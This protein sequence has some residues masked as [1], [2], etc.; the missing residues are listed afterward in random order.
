MEPDRTD[1]ESGFRNPAMVLRSVLLPA[2]LRPTQATISRGLT[3]R[4]ISNR[5]FDA[6]YDTLRSFTA[7]IS[8]L[9]AALGSGS[10]SA[11]LRG[12]VDLP[13]ASSHFGMP[14]AFLVAAV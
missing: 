3:L 9:A 7:S 1:P 8:P 12:G 4:P 5:T 11:A 6:P 10:M 14:Q 2:P 13:V